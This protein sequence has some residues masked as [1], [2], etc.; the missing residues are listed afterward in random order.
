M[1]EGLSHITFVVGDLERS[2]RMLEYILGAEEVYSSG[3]VVHSLAPEKFFRVG[4][5]WLV[6][7]RGEPSR[8]R[9]YDHVAFRVAETDLDACLARIEELGLEVKEDRPRFPGEGR[10]IY[11]YDYDNHLFELHAGSLE[12]RLRE[13][14]EGG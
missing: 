12:G 9:T 4:D 1:V 11:F 5:A 14:R 3:E 2:G 13:Y 8:S 10:S 7:M 6:L